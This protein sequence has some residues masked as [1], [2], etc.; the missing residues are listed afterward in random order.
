MTTDTFERHSQAHARACAE[1][2]YFEVVAIQ[3]EIDEETTVLS[4]QNDRLQYAQVQAL[5]AIAIA[6][7][8]TSR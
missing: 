8:T 6:L 5:V 2:A 3:N 1:A 4:D 7:T